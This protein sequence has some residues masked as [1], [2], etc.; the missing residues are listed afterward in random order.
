VPD[1]RSPRGPR[2]RSRRGPRRGPPRS[3]AR[4][5]RRPSASFRPSAR[6][7]RQCPVS[8]AGPA[9]TPL[10]KRR[11]PS[12]STRAHHARPGRERHEARPAQ[13]DRGGERRKIPGAARRRRP[14]RAPSRVRAEHHAGPAPLRRRFVGV[15]PPGPLRCPPDRWSRPKPLGRRFA[16]EPLPSV[17][18]SASTYI[19][20]APVPGWRPTCSTADQR[21]Y[22]AHPSSS[23]AWGSAPALGRHRSSVG[24]AGVHVA[25]DAHAGVVVRTRSSVLQRRA[26][27]R[28]PR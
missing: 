2:H 27:C 25:D 5:S 6:P 22:E 24:V 15:P 16:R 20:S 17:A 26:R 4:P 8:R 10:P 23:R 19:V 3:S 9:R 1:Q 7:G 28:R 13:L 11:A 14:R 12:S 21:E 18:S